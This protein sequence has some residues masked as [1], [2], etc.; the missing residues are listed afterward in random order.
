MSDG[1]CFSRRLTF[2]NLSLMDIS[3]FIRREWQKFTDTKTSGIYLHIYDFRTG[4]KTK[5]K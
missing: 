1:E 3:F 5:R 2:L 4:E